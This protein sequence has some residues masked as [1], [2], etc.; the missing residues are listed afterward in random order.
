[1]LMMAGSQAKQT[2]IKTPRG[3]AWPAETQTIEAKTQAQLSGSGRESQLVNEDP[4]TGTHI[5]R[6]GRSDG[7]DDDRYDAS[8]DVGV[9]EV[10]SQ[11]RF[12]PSRGTNGMKTRGQ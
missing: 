6:K 10:E 2:K 8:R 11:K 9:G 3:Q 12:R 4:G 1:M 7:D 5:D